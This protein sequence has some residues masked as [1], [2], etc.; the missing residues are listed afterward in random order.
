MDRDSRKDYK[1]CSM[2]A[3]KRQF[4][5]TG[6]NAIETKCREKCSE[7]LNCIAMSGVWGEFCIGCKETLTSPHPGTVAFIRGTNICLL[8]LSNISS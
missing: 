4:K 7:D 5:L 6:A 1:K 3:S 2:E 8:H